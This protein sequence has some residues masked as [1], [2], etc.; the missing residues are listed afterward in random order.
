MD[1]EMYGFGDDS[2][3]GLTVVILSCTYNTTS[4]TVATIKIHTGHFD[5]SNASD[6]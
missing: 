3:V 2:C 5:G 6:I 4:S 1:A